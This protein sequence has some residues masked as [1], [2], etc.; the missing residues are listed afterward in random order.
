MVR[1]RLLK[2]HL[3]PL[4]CNRV[5]SEHSGGAHDSTWPQQ[6]GRF[7]G[8]HLK[9]YILWHHGYESERI[10]PLKFLSRFDVSRPDW[11]QVTRCRRVIEELERVARETGLVPANVQDLGTYDKPKLLEFFDKAYETLLIKLYGESGIY[12]EGEKAIGTLYDRVCG[13]EN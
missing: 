13:M 11:T 10:Q 5:A 2:K 1:I 7:H 4:T 6:V 3:N 12:R 8:R 9:F